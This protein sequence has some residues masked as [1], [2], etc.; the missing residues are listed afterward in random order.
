[1]D[2]GSAV[3]CVSEEI[4]KVNTSELAETLNRLPAGL[5]DRVRTIATVRPRLLLTS[6]SG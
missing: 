1:M 2:V 6:L 4:K 5:R 3:V